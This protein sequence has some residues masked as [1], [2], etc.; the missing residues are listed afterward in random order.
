M[1]PRSADN[2]LRNLSPINTK[3]SGKFAL[4]N[5]AS[6]VAPTNGFDLFRSQLREGIFFSVETTRPPSL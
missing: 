1:F 3:L 5:V 4:K 2:D 6:F